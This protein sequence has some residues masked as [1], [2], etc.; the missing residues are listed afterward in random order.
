MRRLSWLELKGIFTFAVSITAVLFWAYV[1]F[2]ELFFDATLCGYEHNPYIA[3]FELVVF[4][5]G[6]WFIIERFIY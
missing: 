6:A 2:I 4:S 5:I 1:F 3:G